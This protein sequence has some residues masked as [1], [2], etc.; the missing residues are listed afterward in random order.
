MS[1]CDVVLPPAIRSH[2]GSDHLLVGRAEET[3]LYLT[4]KNRLH[5]I[6]GPDGMTGPTHPSDEATGNFSLQA[7]LSQALWTFR[8]HG[9]L[10]SSSPR[11][12]FSLQLLFPCTLQPIIPS[13]H[14]KMSELVGSRIHAFVVMLLYKEEPILASMC[15]PWKFKINSTPLLGWVKASTLLEKEKVS[16]RWEVAVV[17][18]TATPSE[19]PKEV[20]V[21]CRQAEEFYQTFKEELIPILLKLFQKTKEGTPPNSLYKAS[22]TKIKDTIKRKREKGN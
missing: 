17:P 16:E 19:R 14:F 6:C 11:E 10:S 13:G 3:I 22:I 5:L 12:L 21:S 7:I 15:Q 2:Y 20:W 4:V 18:F 9:H 8:C 1:R